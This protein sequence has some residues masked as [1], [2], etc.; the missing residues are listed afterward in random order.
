MASGSD[1]A[2]NIRFL[3]DAL[4]FL[5]GKPVQV[6]AEIFAIA[7]WLYGFPGVDGETKF[8][9]VGPRVFGVRTYR[10]VYIDDSYTMLYELDGE[11]DPPLL[12][13]IDIF[14]T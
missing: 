14:Q 8:L 9:V 2:P 4:E 13:V 10:R 3:K 6:Q 12:T 5:D 11:A 1:D 7:S